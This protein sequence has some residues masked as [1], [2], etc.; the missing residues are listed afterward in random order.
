MSNPSEK[1]PVFDVQVKVGKEAIHEIYEAL[2]KTP[3]YYSLYSTDAVVNE[4]G[5]Y[6]T[7]LGKRIAENGVLAKELLA[8]S[9][10]PVSYA[11]YYKSPQ[12]EIRYLPHDT[13]ISTDLILY[14]DKLILMSYDGELRTVVIQEKAIFDT[15]KMMFDLLWESTPE[16][17]DVQSVINQSTVL[18]KD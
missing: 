5:T 16:F 18:K 7:D 17:I 15:A 2:V 11:H 14:E 1:K 3:W 9:V 6:S 4:W 12:Q 13:K 10:R 8:G